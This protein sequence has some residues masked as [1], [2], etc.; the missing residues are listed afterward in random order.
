[1]PQERTR[2]LDE[3]TN[4]DGTS[5]WYW[6][7]RGHKIQRLSDDP[8][9]R[10]AEQLWL[11]ERADRGETAVLPEKNAQV[12]DVHPRG[13]LGWVADQWQDNELGKRAEGT[14]R[15][16]RQWLRE[17]RELGEATPF[18]FFEDYEPVRDFITSFNQVGGPHKAKATL[19]H[20]FVEAMKHRL[21]KTNTTLL[22]SLEATE[23]RAV[24]W[25]DPEINRWEDA[26]RE[27]DHAA[28][29]I[30]AM[31]LL[32]NTVQRFNDCLGLPR[33]AWDGEKIK[34]RQEKTH[35]L[36]WVPATDELRDFLNRHL[37]AWDGEFIVPHPSRGR[38]PYITAAKAFRDIC[39]IAGVVDRQPRDLRR[40]AAVRMSEEGATPQQIAAVGGW[41]IQTVT[42]ILETYI[43]RTHKMAVEGVEALN[44][45]NARRQGKNP[46]APAPAAAAAG[47]EAELDAAL[48]AALATL[49]PAQAEA[50][51]QRFAARGTGRSPTP[52]AA[53][54]LRI[55]KP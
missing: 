5:R 28:T 18:R 31:M 36:V 3:R 40:T 22:V 20:L 46:H 50:L 7:R 19:S 53:P 1:M 49:P 13:S 41:Q 4:E 34:L 35:Q 21:V 23:R 38:C 52:P 11:N 26:A 42:S 15:W 16:L 43:P 48:E 32:R 17:I 2:Y 10:F 37:A 27:H 14:R 29:M 55:V 9:E 47:T 25:E 33:T 51:R 54:R 8:A 39:E 44:R 45:V 6:R 24:M 30:P 12:K